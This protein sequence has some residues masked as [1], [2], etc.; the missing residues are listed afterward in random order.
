MTDEAPKLGY[1]PIRAGE[2]IQGSR[3]AVTDQSGVKHWR[4]VL[5]ARPRIDTAPNESLADVLGVDPSE[6][7]TPAR[8]GLRLRSRASD[9]HNV[10]DG[11]HAPN[12]TRG[13]PVEVSDEDGKLLACPGKVPEAPKVLRDDGTKVR[14]EEYGPQATLPTKPGGVV[15][16]PLSG[17]SP[18]MGS[19]QVTLLG[20]AARPSYR[21]R[22]ESR[23][24]VFRASEDERIA[25]FLRSDAPKPRDP[26]RDFIEKGA[27]I[28]DAL[29]RL[30][31]GGAVR[32]V[33]KAYESEDPSAAP[34][35]PKSPA[36]RAVYAEHASRMKARDAG[37]AADKARRLA[38]S[39]RVLDVRRKV[40][41]A[42]LA[43]EIAERARERAIAATRAQCAAAIAARGIAL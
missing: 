23:Q 33:R 2:P 25:E 42:V 32:E 26:D 1:S 5:G 8:K 21:Q 17:R 43:S 29:D 14:I 13:K 30:N 7:K 38:E 4:N 20:K 36:A 16:A 6:A 28:K 19:T 34:D 24:A 27:G 10:T 18:G 12:T 22:A 9:R 3:V 39:A 11:L 40:E 15:V 35:L 31:D 41:R 37:M